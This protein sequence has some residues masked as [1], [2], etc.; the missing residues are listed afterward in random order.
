MPQ[1]GSGVTY[2][3]PPSSLLWAFV[4][5]KTDGTH[6]LVSWTGKS[7]LCLPV[8][9]EAFC[10]GTLVPTHLELSSYLHVTLLRTET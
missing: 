1:P 8:H 6:C 10:S 9:L 4:L 2:K 5:S 7:L 3:L